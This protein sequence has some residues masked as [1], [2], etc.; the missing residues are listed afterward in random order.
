VATKL[1]RFAVTV[2]PRAVAWP[3]TIRLV[4]GALMLDAMIVAARMLVY[5]AADFTGLN[6]RFLTLVLLM[7]APLFGFHMIVFR[8]LKG[9]WRATRTLVTLMAVWATSGVI[10]GLDPLSFLDAAAGLIMGIAVWTPSARAYLR[11]V[12]AAR[13]ASRG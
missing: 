7:L 2:A 13:R 6:L 8:S 5:L 4:F 11:E 9:G 10:Y 1:E 12:A 3:P